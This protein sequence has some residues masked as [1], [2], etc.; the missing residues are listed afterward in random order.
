MDGRLLFAR[1]TCWLLIAASLLTSGCSRKFW[2]EQA[3]Q[4][5][6]RV[7]AEKLNDPRW[8]VP[9]IDVIPSPDSRNFPAYDP[10]KPE[11]PPDDPAAN[12]SMHCVS[13]GLKGYK[14]WDEF[15]YMPTIENPTWNIDPD[16]PDN[17]AQI[18]C[19]QATPGVQ[20][21]LQQEKIEDLTLPQ[22]LEIST[23]QSREYQTVIEAVY[24]AALALT[25]ERFRFDV[26]Y[27]GFGSQE[28]SVDVEY[29]SIPGVQDSLEVDSAFGISRLLPTGGQFIVE[30]A[31]NTLFF[32]NGDD[33]TLTMSALSYSFVQPLLRGAG[34]KVVLESLTQSERD[35]LYAVRDLAR[36]RKVF[37]TDTV[38]DGP[39]G[40]FLGLLTQRQLIQ[41]QV[42]NIVQL[43]NQLIALEERQDDPLGLEQLRT[44]LAESENRLRS[45]QLNFQN[46]LDRFKLQLGLPTDLPMT[47]DERLLSPFDL[48]DEQLI[49]VENEIMSDA[50][51]G[52]LRG[53]ID[54]DQPT[55][56]F[57]EMRQLID[58]KLLPLYTLVEEQAVPLIE[59]DLQRA[60][61]LLTPDETGS[62]VSTQVFGVTRQLGSTEE[63]VLLAE[64]LDRDRQLFSQLQQDLA[65]LKGRIESL[66]QI[67]EERLGGV[68]VDEFVQ[69]Y[70]TTPEGMEGH[71][72]LSIDELPE[73]WGELYEMID[74]DRDGIQPQEILDFFLGSI[75]EDREALLSITQG[76]KVIQVDARVEIIPLLPFD[77]PL[78]EAVETGLTE[79]LDLM[80]VRARVMDARRRIE[81]FANELE[82]TL[83]VRVEGDLRTPVGSRPFN[84]RG[85]QSSFRV[86]VGFVAPLDRVLERN[87]FRAA[88]IEYDRVR[89]VYIDAEDNV[90]FDIRQAWRTI[91]VSRRNFL[92]ARLNVRSAARQLDQTI[93]AINAP[94]DPQGGRRNTN[95]GLNL[96][97][98]LNSV[99]NAQNEL[100]GI[101]I[102]FEQ[103]RLNIYRDMGIMNID[104]DGVWT[105]PF[106]QSLANQ[107]GASLHVDPP[108]DNQRQILD[109][110]NTSRSADIEPGEDSDDI[111]PAAADVFGA[112]LAEFF[113]TDTAVP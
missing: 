6:Y 50:P 12:A 19:P 16:D 60:E 27:L 83:D 69:Q 87:D 20:F 76:L 103:A 34:R 48:I 77:M 9:R 97:N 107:A 94:P 100:I 24:L 49:S 56:T 89:R 53:L 11:L 62:R 44:R 3:D 66:L 39:S 65:Q 5:T 7:L 93:D 73:G 111:E 102:D 42:F 38:I 74:F 25:F 63:R 79:R 96:L 78:D 33:Q 17:E 82:A 105:D 10:F 88:L 81:I 112:E 55:T 110:D 47:L 43:E 14:N 90:K 71:G 30:L 104:E 84:F 4:D 37:F 2:R 99:L 35:V 109:G 101:W 31:N 95:N 29:E 72:S 32:F 26:R 59:A 86:G 15:G 8:Q 106:Y 28:P 40:G 108:H 64:A 61:A 54:L 18:Y 13:R 36:F 22:A 91:D 1:P 41:N 67:L 51:D 58:D 75:A 57:G 85:D 52:L 46:N 92:T 45:S 70:D 23:I 21:L 68:S 98:A 80:N 113:A